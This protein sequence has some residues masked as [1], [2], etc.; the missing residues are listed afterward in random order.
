MEVKAR[1]HALHIPAAA[2]WN[3]GGGAP[4]PEYIGGGWEK[5]SQGFWSVA[6]KNVGALL[7]NL[8]SF[9]AEK[10]GYDFRRYTPL[11]PD[12]HIP[13]P[14]GSGDYPDGVTVSELLSGF[15]EA[16][17]ALSYDTTRFV[18]CWQDVPVNKVLSFALDTDP[19]PP[20]MTEECNQIDGWKGKSVFANTDG[21]FKE[22]AK[23]GRA[24]FVNLLSAPDDQYWQ[25]WL[26]A[27]PGE[28]SQGHCDRHGLKIAGQL[29][30]P[31]K[32]SATDIVTIA[33]LDR[34]I[35]LISKALLQADP[36]KG[37]TPQVPELLSIDQVN[38][39]LHTLSDW[40]ANQVDVLFVQESVSIG[41]P[42]TGYTRCEADEVKD[43]KQADAA[44]LMKSD[45]YD[46]D[47]TGE[48]KAVLK[49]LRVALG[50]GTVDISGDVDGDAAKQVAKHAVDLWPQ[51][52][53]SQSKYK[54]VIMTFWTYEE[55]LPRIAVAVTKGDH[56]DATI[57]VNAHGESTGYTP[58]E[59]LIMARLLQASMG[60]TTY[61]V[62]VGMDSN[63]APTGAAPPDALDSPAILDIAEK[64]EFGYPTPLG[65]DATVRKMRG[66][67]QAQLMKG[68]KVDRAFK[69][70]IFYRPP[71]G[72]AAPKQLAYQIVNNPE[73]PK[74]FLDTGF[75]TDEYPLDHFLV[76]MKSTEVSK[77]GAPPVTVPDDGNEGGKDDNGKG[78]DGDGDDDD[79]KPA[80]GW[81]EADTGIWICIFSCIFSSVGAFIKRQVDKAKAAREAAEEGVEM[82]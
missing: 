50:K 37:I 80:E 71:S 4:K 44:I 28:L 63:A 11:R 56:G 7:L 61:G 25:L 82:S 9:P 23:F 12:R 2:T 14:D 3:A 26:K 58:G 20:L 81:T 24:G 62:M 76:F 42:P 74:T 32:L 53:N 48:A 40:I 18:S 52:K 75:P 22:R 59:V 57:L 45:L 65:A 54:S 35:F 70:Y 6:E 64:L 51:R 73:D 5:V 39:R 30:S 33:L 1:R 29:G 27:L 13:K 17:E 49:K 55:D 43:G 46:A 21:C 8:A 78:D 72:H 38:A 41:D 60:D 67:V 31:P 19:T 66:F 69:D 79:S 10:D 77:L 34:L 36:Y 47:K 15:K 68:G 16:M